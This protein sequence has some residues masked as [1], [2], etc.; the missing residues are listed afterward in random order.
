MGNETD[1]APYRTITGAA[2]ALRDGEISSVELTEAFLAR[3]DRHNDAVRALVEVYPRQA[4]AAAA[5]AD[6][7]RAAGVVRSPLQ[8]VPIA[9]KDVI[10]VEEGPTRGGGNA[11]SPRWHPGDALAVARLRAAGAI[12]LGKSLTMEFA[13][14][15]PDERD[16]TPVSANPWNLANWAGGSSSGAGA[17]LAAGLFL[18]GLGTDTGGSIRCPAAWCGVSGIKPSYGLVPTEGMIPWAF[19]LDHLGPLARSAADCALLLETLADGLP[20]PAGHAERA[21]GDLTGLRIGV[22]RAHHLTSEV[23]EPAVRQRF[24]EA[25]AVLADAG[26]RLSEV[27]LP[28]YD[29]AAEAAMLITPVEGYSYHRENLRERWSDYGRQTRLQIAAGAVIGAAD[30]VQARRVAV[31][32][33]RRL[34]ALFAGVDLIVMPTTATG[35]PP[36]AALYG[37]DLRHLITSTIYTP[38]WD[39]VGNPALSV[40]MGLN[41]AGLPLGLQIAGAHGADALVLHA[42]AAFQARTDHHLA[43]PPLRPAPS[44]AAVP[45]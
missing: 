4:L 5:R 16:G 21:P 22:E 30:Y 37:A 41:A 25:L 18:G 20:A 6:A 11:W 3:I 27:E 43:V 12:V 19:T 45:A 14:G 24:D 1:A 35:A 26:A 7:D 2:A 34:A 13:C 10:A 38:Y 42:G 36:I 33:Q 29:T 28:L 40:P 39:V 15:M 44:S 9:V 32:A 31:L 8:G 17:G 23:V